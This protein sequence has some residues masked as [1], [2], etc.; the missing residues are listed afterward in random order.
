MKAYELKALLATLD[1]SAEVSIVLQER[2]SRWQ[3]IP[4]GPSEANFDVCCRCNHEAAIVLC[5]NAFGFPGIGAGNRIE[6]LE[7]ENEELEQ[8]LDDLKEKT[9]DLLHCCVRTGDDTRTDRAM[10]ALEKIL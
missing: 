10:D 9:K 2:E 8:Q 6:D 3:S 1:D 7:S 4:K 5:A